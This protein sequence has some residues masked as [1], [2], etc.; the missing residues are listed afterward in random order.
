[1]PELDQRLR[2]LNTARMKQRDPQML[3][4]ESHLWS[5]KIASS[6]RKCMNM[7]EIMEGGLSHIRVLEVVT[8]CDFEINVRFAL[9]QYIRPRCNARVLNTSC[10][11]L[12]KY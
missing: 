3:V 10:A 5:N 9:P 4:L 7:K 1:M 11:K 12:L 8:T 6:T 2:R